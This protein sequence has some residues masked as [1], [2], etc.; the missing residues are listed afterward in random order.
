MDGV[1]PWDCVAPRARSLSHRSS[2]ED[3]GHGATA[4]DLE[5]RVLDGAA[6]AH[7]VEL[8]GLAG[9]SVTPSAARER[10]AI[11]CTCALVQR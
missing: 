5:Q 11:Y 1:S 9:A 4:G 7:L 10:W 6:V 2:D 8:E 3:V